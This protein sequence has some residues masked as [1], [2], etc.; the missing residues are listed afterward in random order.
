MQFTE[1]KI[2]GVWVV[3]PK[4]WG[5]ERGY[6]METWRA[7]DMALETGMKNFWVQDNESKSS[8]GVLRGLHFQTGEYAQSKLVRVIEGEVFDV[9][10]DIRPESET[11]GEHFAIVLSGENKKQLLVPR[12]MAHGF[13]VLS[14]TAT[15]VYKCDNYYASEHQL[16]I[17]F[18]DE[19]LNIAWPDVGQEYNLSPKDKE[20]PLFSEMKF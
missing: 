16:A 7:E 8:K 2:K 6:F 19:K 13:L 17:N 20:A 9:V 3:E 4:V 14:E 5:D 18:A 12:G 1:T 11:F 15:F 10:V